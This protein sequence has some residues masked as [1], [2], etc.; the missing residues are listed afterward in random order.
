MDSPLGQSR[1][2][3]SS[4]P[5][6][7]ANSERRARHPMSARGGRAARRRRRRRRPAAPRH[8]PL[9]RDTDPRLPMP[10]SRLFGI[11]YDRFKIQSF[12]FHISTIHDRSPTATRAVR[13]SSIADRAART[14]FESRRVFEHCCSGECGRPWGSGAAGVRTGRGAA[15]AQ[16]RRRPFKR[17]PPALHAPLRPSSRSQPCTRSTAR[18]RA[19]TDHIPPHLT[20]HS[21]TLP[22]PIIMLIIWPFSK[23]AYLSFFTFA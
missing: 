23:F 16:P 5:A 12:G 9:P 3:S 17:R 6:G 10:H 21:R 15:G 14:W 7:A 18:A 22:P 1:A 2:S 8:H 20:P 13:S 19:R 4:R 11:E